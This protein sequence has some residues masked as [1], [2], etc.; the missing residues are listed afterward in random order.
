M[1]GATILRRLQPRGI[2]LAPRPAPEL[3][4]CP[5]GRVVPD[6]LGRFFYDAQN[7]VFY[8]A[9]GMTERDWHLVTPAEMVRFQVRSFVDFLGPR[10]HA[11]EF[12]KEEIAEERAAAAA[13][14]D[15]PA[16]FLDAEAMA[17]AGLRVSDAR[18]WTTPAGTRC[19]QARLKLD[20][21]T[22][23]QVFFGLAPEPVSPV[24]PV[25]WWDSS[26]LHV[27]NRDAAGF[28]YDDHSPERW[29]ILSGGEESGGCIVSGARAGYVV[30]RLEIGRD[31]DTAFFVDGAV[32]SHMHMPS[33]G[34]LSPRISLFDYGSAA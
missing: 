7:S 2:A 30:L 31:G 19:A 20:L 13:R 32:V 21:Q 1:P 22:A 16:H 28:L 3:V 34:S 17:Q 6:H 12:T 18:D 9:N 8:R 5:I 11:Q 24:C 23:G 26:L 29:R 10:H 4:H 27:E 15:R 14:M 33:A 25:G